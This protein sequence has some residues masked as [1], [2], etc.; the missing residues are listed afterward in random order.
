ME[1]ML[2]IY[3]DIEQFLWKTYSFSLK[4]ISNR[5]FEPSNGSYLLLVTK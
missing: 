2:I 5:L 1:T 3:H 4:T